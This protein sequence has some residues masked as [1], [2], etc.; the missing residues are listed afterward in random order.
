MY[1]FGKVGLDTTENMPSKVSDKSKSLGRN[2]AS[3]VK[4]K[5]QHHRRLQRTWESGIV[6]V[7][8]SANFS[9]LDLGG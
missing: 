2:I 6:R 8:V 9:G 4:E 7:D 5:T 1:S 3:K